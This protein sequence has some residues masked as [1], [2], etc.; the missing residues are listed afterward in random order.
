MHETGLLHYV[1]IRRTFEGR[2]G[3]A[4]ERQIPM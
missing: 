2:V 4:E 3:V 1:R